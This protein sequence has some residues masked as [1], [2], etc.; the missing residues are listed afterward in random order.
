MKSCWARGPESELAQNIT[1]IPE[2][3]FEISGNYTS[4]VLVH[5]RGGWRLFVLA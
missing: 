1:N 4:L 3:K 2:T 5:E